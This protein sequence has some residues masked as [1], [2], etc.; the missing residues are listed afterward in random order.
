MTKYLKDIKN[1]NIEKETEA[2]L[3]RIEK[4]ERDIYF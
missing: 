4:G 2:R 1:K 3:K